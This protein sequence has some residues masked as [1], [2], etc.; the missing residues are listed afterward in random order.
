[1]YISRV[2]IS[3]AASDSPEFWRMSS[4]AYEIHQLV[5]G[6]F[7][8][9]AD[10]KRMFLYRQELHQRRPQLIVVSAQSPGKGDRRG[11]TLWHV[12]TKPYAPKLN[13]GEQLSFVLRANPV[14]TRQEQEGRRRRHDV[15]MDYKRQVRSRGIQRSEWPPE[16]VIVQEQCSQWLGARASK[17][18][19]AIDEHAVR[20]EGYRQHDLRRPGGGRSIRFSTVDFTGILT[21]VDPVRFVHTLLHGIGPAKGFGCGLLLVRRP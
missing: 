8:Q 5:W 13:A 10:G 4:S 18:G 12:E 21:V 19:F 9:P 20:A 14:I 11:S 16:Y 7:E 1:M 3:A 17:A 15:V 6:I 2:S